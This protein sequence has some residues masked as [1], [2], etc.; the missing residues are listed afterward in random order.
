[1][2]LNNTSKKKRSLERSLKNIF[3]HFITLKLSKFM[4]NSKS[5]R[6]LLCNSLNKIT[7]T[8]RISTI[9]LILGILQAQASD[10]YSQKTRISLN[11]KETRLNTVLDKIEKESDFFFLYNEK[12]LDIDR[13][14]TIDAKDD[15]I[16][17]ILKNLFAG[18]DVKFTIIDRKIILAPGYL[19]GVSTENNALQ[20]QKITGTVTDAATGEPIIG[21][22]I[23]VESTTIGVV[24]DVNGQYSIELP[25]PNSILV[26]SFI[27]FVTEKMSAAGSTNLDVKLISDIKKLDD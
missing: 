22:N 8:M 7:L 25:N 6:G 11:L 4:K 14:V 13:K 3:Q 27:G 10:I 19:S 16:S 9:L 26:I 18:T 23:T 17:D 21:A 15:L 24:T 20:K 5:F 2:V 12:L 1:M